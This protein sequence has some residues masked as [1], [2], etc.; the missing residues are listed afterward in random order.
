[1]N[2]SWWLVAAWKCQATRLRLDFGATS[3]RCA[4]R[5]R[6]HYWT[7]FLASCMIPALRTTCHRSDIPQRKL[8]QSCLYHVK[9]CQE[10]LLHKIAFQSTCVYLVTFISSW[11]WPSDLDTI[12][13]PRYYE[14]VPTYQNEVCKS[15]HWK[16]RASTGQTGIQAVATERITT[17]H[18]RVV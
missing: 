4:I 13:W 17:P 12:P 18:L 5:R 11:P 1:M 10:L 16:L 9:F 6:V 8:M 14:Y 15:R 7:D 3:R 2:T